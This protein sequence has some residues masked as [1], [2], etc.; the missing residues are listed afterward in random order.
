MS[1]LALVAVA[2]LGLSRGEIHAA[3]SPSLSDR[4]D[5]RIQAKLDAEGVSRAAPADDAEFLRR[6]YLDLHGRVPTAEQAAKFLDKN[7]AEGG[8]SG[9]RAE[10]VDELL[11]DPRFGE[12]FA[13]LWR[14]QLMSPA[15]NEQRMQSDRFAGWLAKRFNDND[16]WNK[17]V[18]DLLTATGKME[19]NPAVT[20]LIEGRYPLPVTDLADL[21]SRYFLGIR[22]NCAQCHDHPFAEWKQ[23]DYW[24]IASFFAEIQTPQRAK[25]V[26]MA[27]VQDNPKVTMTTLRDADM[28]EGFKSEPPK[29]L[30]GETFETRGKEPLRVALARWMTA[31]DNRFFARAATNRLW[32]HFFG[33]GIIN[34]ADDMHAGNTASHPELLD[35][36]GREFSESNFDIKSFCRAIANSRTYQQTSRPGGNMKNANAKNAD[37]KNDSADRQAADRQGELFA[38]MSIKVLTA[39]QLYDSLVTV[40]GPPSKSPGLDQRFGARY[41]FTNY[42]AGDRDAEPIRYDRGIPHALRMMNSPQFGRSLPALAANLA[43]RGRNADEV[44]DDLYLTILSRRPTAEERKFVRSR[45]DDAKSTAADVYQEIAWALLMGSEFS[46]NH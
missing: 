12:Y 24:G 18:Y 29:F 37:S 45:L 22:L 46:L 6:V 38:R 28:I 14:K 42:F 32:R 26:Y 1:F 4:I 10:L 27:G 25:L 35:E 41:E 43:E 36:L 2:S 3:D 7:S 5:D 11:A 20:Y 17:I 16:G 21:S 8:S 23:S 13:D 44:V 34:P 15:V 30:G 33:R 9:K 39:E 40:V 31:S 19:D